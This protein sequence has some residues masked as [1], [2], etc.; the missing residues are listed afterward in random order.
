MQWDKLVCVFTIFVCMCGENALCAS[1]D[2][3]ILIQIIGA[4]IL[5]IKL[6]LLLFMVLMKELPSCGS[7]KKLESFSKEI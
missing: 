3:Q 5:R 6:Y 2:M 7:L 4:I 1:K